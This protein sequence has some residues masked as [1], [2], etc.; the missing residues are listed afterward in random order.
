MTVAT[1]FLLTELGMDA[2]LDNLEADGSSDLTKSRLR[3]AGT[4]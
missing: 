4:G 3:K 1:V 2:A